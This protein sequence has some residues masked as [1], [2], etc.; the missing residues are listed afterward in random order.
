[1]KKYRSFTYF[2]VLAYV[3]SF[4]PLRTSDIYLIGDKYLLKMCLTYYSHAFS[5]SSLLAYF[6]VQKYKKSPLKFHTVNQSI[7]QKIQFFQL[8]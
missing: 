7:N 8:T 5:D 2:D 3:K 4:K 6:G 1:M